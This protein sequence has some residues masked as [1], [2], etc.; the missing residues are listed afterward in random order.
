MVSQL[1][2][3]LAKAAYPLA[4]WLTTIALVSIPPISRHRRRIIFGAFSSLRRKLPVVSID[5]I[6]AGIPDSEEVRLGVLE[7]RAHNM[8]LFEVLCLA[9]ITRKFAPSV[10]LEIGTYDGRSTMALARNMTGRVYTVNLGPDYKDLHPDQGH[11]VDIQLSRKV[12][13]GERALAPEH[14]TNCSDFLRLD[15]ARFQPVRRGGPDSNR[16]RP[17]L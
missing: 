3:L 17:W 13:S 15:E 10:A 16:R 4:T 6:L 12:R 8:S 2:A 1:N 11:R 9:A 7:T 14:E 5:K